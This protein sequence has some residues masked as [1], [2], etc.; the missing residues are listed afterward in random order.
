M[1]VIF[2]TLEPQHDT[3]GRKYNIHP[4]LEAVLS[5]FKTFNSL[6]AELMPITSAEVMAAKR[7]LRITSV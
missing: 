5:E 6:G 1:K 7:P 3:V 2:R 4:I